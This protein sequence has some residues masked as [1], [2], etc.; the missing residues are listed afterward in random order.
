MPAALV[1]PVPAPD[2]GLRQAFGENVK[3]QRRLADL[4]QDELSL[5][6]ELNR[7]EISQLERGMRLP[8]LDTILKLL[9]GLEAL[10]S[11]LLEGMVWSPGIY[12]SGNFK[13]SDHSDHADPGM[14]PQLGS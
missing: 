7:T 4:S 5:R 3:R 13:V 12:R 11:E 14:K 2:P 1:H 9:S 6:C 10:P 8:R